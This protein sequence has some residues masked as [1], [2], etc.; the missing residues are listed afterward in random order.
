LYVPN[1]RTAADLA[2]QE[3]LNGGAAGSFTVQLTL[4]D[5]IKTARLLAADPYYKTWSI[6]NSI[7]P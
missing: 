5:K 1:C 3:A 7:K 4:K 6:I 2:A